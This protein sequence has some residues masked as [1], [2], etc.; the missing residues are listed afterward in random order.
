MA[1][2]RF[3]RE[4][5]VSQE[6][7]SFGTATVANENLI[8]IEGSNVGTEYL[9]NFSFSSS[10]E[11]SGTLFA[12]RGL[13]QGDFSYNV[14]GLSTDVEEFVDIQTRG[15]LNDLLRFVLSERDRAELSEGDDR[16]NLFNGNDLMFGRGGDDTLRGG[17][18]DDRLVGGAGEDRLIGGNGADRLVGNSGDDVIR[19]GAGNDLI[20]GGSGNDRLKGN[21]G[22]DRIVG[23][24]GDDTLK[25]GG[26][27]DEFVSRGKN[28]TDTIEDFQIGLDRISLRQADGLSDLLI[29]Q[30]GNDAVISFGSLSIVVENTRSDL[31]DFEDFLF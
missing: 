19:G 3:F 15:D 2:I 12:F 26:G 8:R 10:G 24:G 17:Q 1:K 6:F 9:G 29:A 28:R 16:L 23:G 13:Q 31:L 18:G 21:G 5:D 22:N 25:G 7:I 4:I 11:V 14:T 20:R 30:D 27:A